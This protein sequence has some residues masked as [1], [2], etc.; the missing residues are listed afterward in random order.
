MTVKNISLTG[1][2]S[3]DTAAWKTI[4]W[5]TIQYSVN[6]LQ[7]RIAKAVQAG[8]HSKARTLQ[9][10][11]T[12]SFHAKL[13]ATKRVTQNRGSKTAGVDGKI[14][15]TLKQKMQLALSL[16]RH[17]Y[18]AQPLRRVY[19]PKKN[20]KTEHRPLSIPTIRDRA[21][22][23][24]YLLALEPI[25]EI[26]ADP[27]SY[28]F[29]PERCTADAIEQCFR[30][31]AQ[32][33]FAQYILEGDI[34]KCFDKISHTWLKS[35]I[36]MD[37]KILSQWLSVGYMDKHVLY[38]TNEGAPQGGIASPCLAVMTLSGLETAI[39]SAV[40]KRDKVNVIVYADDFV[41][42]G[43]S[44]E[45]LE[46]KVKP[47]IVAFLQERGLELSAT[48]TQITHIDKGFDFLGHQIRKYRGKLLIKPS[49][50]SIKSFLDDVRRIIKRLRGK[51]TLDLI[52]FLNTKIRGWGNY[53]RHVVSKEVFSYVDDCIYRALARWVKRRHPDKNATWWRE[54]YFRPQGRRQ[55]IFSAKDPN[56]NGQWVDLLKMVHIPIKR[57]VKIIAQATPYDL[58]WK[59]YFKQRRLRKK[60]CR[61]ATP[62]TTKK[63]TSAPKRQEK[64]ASLTFLE[65]FLSGKSNQNS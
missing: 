32:K 8:R 59:E 3:S 41:V 64:H 26:K 11:L 18:A 34:R 14:C 10:L 53:Y 24:L 60:R 35:H 6:R 29:R 46:Q 65:S 4:H 1:A 16:Q 61:N 54:K 30:A 39:Q 33:T 13:L 20:S 27:N 44:Q 21:M 49:K 48:K 56:K 17:G 45:M 5:K 55:W 15:R 57:H 23:A 28:G 51:K 58:A 7:M 12:H 22:Q 25:A 9:W 62:K 31:L 50:K 36:P 19:I 43:V 2:S 63:Q 38:P 52:N 37:K 47:I 42:T 40:S